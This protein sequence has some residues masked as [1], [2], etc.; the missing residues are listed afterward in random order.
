MLLFQLGSRYVATEDRQQRAYRAGAT[1][2][3]EPRLN[4]SVSEIV[5]VDWKLNGKRISKY[6]NIS[7]PNQD[8]YSLFKN[9]TLQINDGRQTDSGNYSVNIYNS[10]GVQ[11]TEEKTLLTFLEPVSGVRIWRSCSGS[12]NIT[13]TC[14]VEFGDDVQLLWTWTL[15]GTKQSM[16]SSPESEEHTS[17]LQFE[18]DVPEELTCEASNAVSKMRTKALLCRGYPST[19]A[20]SV[21]FLTV[22]LWVGIVTAIRKMRKDD[23]K[24]T[25]ENIYLD[26]RGFIKNKTPPE[27]PRTSPPE[28]PAYD[29]SRP[30]QQSSSAEADVE[31][32]YVL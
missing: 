20:A 11:I 6:L 13:V 19:L 28:N 32:V 25:E 1:V 2:L 8:K 4:I 30:L 29:V 27:Q 18:D 7:F 21:L 10:D 16:K 22:V 3:L 12:R 26:M 23:K 24:V 14:S 31:D 17:P 9:G 5:D 15:N